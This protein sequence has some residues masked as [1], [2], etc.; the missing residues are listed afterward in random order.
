MRA[1]WQ[2]LS[3]DEKNRGGALM[4]ASGI[5]LPVARLPAKY[6]I[7]A[8]SKSAYEFVDKLKAAGQKYWQIL[9]L[10]TTPSIIYFWQ[11]R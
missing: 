4:R 9:P 3:R 11:N 6:G 1:L 7:G 2:A 10:G 8:F 5:L